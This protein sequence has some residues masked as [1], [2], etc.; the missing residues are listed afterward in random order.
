MPGQLRPMTLRC[1]S[2]VRFFTV[3]GRQ[4]C[5]LPRFVDKN[6]VSC[7]VRSSLVVTQQYPSSP[8]SRA[9]TVC[10]DLDAF[11]SECSR[12]SDC[13][14]SVLLVGIDWVS[15]SSVDSGDN[16]W[17]NRSVSEIDSVSATEPSSFASGYFQ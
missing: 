8:D 13:H 10:I 7:P 14:S 9:S 16:E 5:P 11:S 15:V 4:C 17:S 2:R 6:V 1:R 12:S 3:S